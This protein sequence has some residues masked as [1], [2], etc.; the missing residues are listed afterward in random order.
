M[1]QLL[2]V[3]T[4]SKNLREFE[5]TSDL[6]EVTLF[7]SE[8]LFYRYFHRCYSGELHDMVPS[9]LARPRVTMRLINAQRFSFFQ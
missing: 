9:L 6:G 4:N 5:S 7:F 1:M 8:R 2:L 3:I